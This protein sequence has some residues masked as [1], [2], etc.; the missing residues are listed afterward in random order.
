MKIVGE[1]T[2]YGLG[3]KTWDTIATLMGADDLLFGLVDDPDFMHGLARKLTDIFLN[4][5]KQY[6][7]LNLIDMDA[8]YCHCVSAL[9]SG[10]PK[11]P[12]DLVHNNLK[13]YG[14]GVLPRF[15]RRFPRRCMRNLISNI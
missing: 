15:L 6:E 7:R 2:G 11:E 5:V 10:M 3:C 12:G 9:T 13:R 1:A 8:M 4:T 14:D